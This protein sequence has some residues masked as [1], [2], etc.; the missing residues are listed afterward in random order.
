TEI[1]EFLKNYNSQAQIFQPRLAEALW[2]YYTNITD[3]NQKNSTDEQLL[4][5]KFKQ[6]AYRNATRFNLTVITPETR[7]CII[8]I[9]DVGTAA[10]TNE[11]KLSNVSKC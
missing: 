11:T 9:M 3:Y 10:Q 1:Q 5:A 8:K 2:T 7:R 6:E 4:T